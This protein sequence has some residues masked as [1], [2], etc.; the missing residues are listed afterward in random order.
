MRLYDSK[1]GKKVLTC[2]SSENF[3]F[4]LYICIYYENT[5]HKKDF[6]FGSQ[7]SH[8]GIFAVLYGLT[9]VQMLLLAAPDAGRPPPEIVGAALK[10]SILSRFWWTWDRMHTKNDDECV[11]LK[12]GTFL[13][14]VFFVVIWWYLVW[15]L[16]FLV[17]I[18]VLPGTL[19]WR[20]VVFSWNWCGSFMF[21]D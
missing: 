9:E 13:L 3:A 8:Q 15:W 6:F 4:K 12:T 20:F 2:L 19:T 5:F 18:G 16:F 1:P 14:V 11:P 10:V 17:G 7:P 21:I